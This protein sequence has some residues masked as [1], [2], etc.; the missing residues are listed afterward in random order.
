MPQYNFTSLRL[1]ADEIE[2]IARSTPITV[3]DKVAPDAIAD[4]MLE[5]D[6]DISNAFC[7]EY[8]DVHLIGI[9]AYYSLDR[10]LLMS[11]QGI[12]LMAKSAEDADNKSADNVFHQFTEYADTGGGGTDLAI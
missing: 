6:D 8:R 4:E 9:H 10:A 1:A 5:S 3:G 2:R 12:R 11:A 7:F